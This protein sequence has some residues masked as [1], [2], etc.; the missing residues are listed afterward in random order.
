[1]G[2]GRNSDC[3]ALREPVGDVQEPAAGCELSGPDHVRPYHV[4][5]AAPG[6]ELGP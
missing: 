3:V 2:P 4:Y 1:M 6:L 5:V